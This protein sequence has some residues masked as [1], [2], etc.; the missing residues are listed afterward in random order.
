MSG[1]IERFYGADDV[2]SPRAIQEYLNRLRRSDRAAANE[3]SDTAEMIRQ[4]VE[5]SPGVGILLGL[6]TRRK[7]RLVVEPLFEAARAHDAAAALSV[8]AWQRFYRHFGDAIEATRRQ[9]GSSNRKMDWGD[10]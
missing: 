5:N 9:K 10:A 8:L 1:G 6:D 4:V 7:A 3:I 2:F